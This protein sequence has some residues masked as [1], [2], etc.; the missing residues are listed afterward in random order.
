MQLNSTSTSL[1]IFPLS[2]LIQFF[3]AK[4]F[5]A[6]HGFA[7]PLDSAYF[8]ATT[9][10]DCFGSTPKNRTKVSDPLPNKT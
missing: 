6:G 1:Q 2:T 3:E 10:I 5:A 7:S 9:K 4:D 8:F